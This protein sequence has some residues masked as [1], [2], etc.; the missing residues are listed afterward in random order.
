MSTIRATYIQH[1]SSAVPNITLN[2]SG[3]VVIASGITVTGSITASG[4][5]SSSSVVIPSGSAAAPG[6]YFAGDTDTGLFTASGN[7]IAVTTSGTERLSITSNAYVRLASGTG[8]IQFNGDT[9][10]TNALD[11]YEEGTFTPVIEGTTGAGTASYSTRAGTYT[12]IG[13]MVTVY[14]QVTW[15]S[16]TGTGNLRVTGLPFTSN[17]NYVTA[18]GATAGLALTDQ[19]AYGFTSSSNVINVGITSTNGTS[20]AASYAYDAAGSIWITLTYFIA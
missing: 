8:G 7:T 5:V 3:D 9:A 19:Y 6:I 15:S 10:A 1:G 18:M 2:A 14:C 13:N 4:F 11:D 16:G 17:E 20:T 12:K